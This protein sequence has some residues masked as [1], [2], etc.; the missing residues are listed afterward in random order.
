MPSL[1]TLHHLNI[2]IHVAAG[3][4][5]MLAGLIVLSLPKGDRRHRIGGRITLSLAGLG[6]AAALIGAFVFRGRVDLMGVSV[7]TSYQIW[8]GLRSLRLKDGGRRPLDF[9][10]AL[11]LF[12]LGL[13]VLYLYRR[14]GA[15]Y[16][17]PG[18]VYAT[19]GGM[20]F[21]GGWDLLRTAFPL[22]W[23]LRLNP[24]EHGFKMTSLIGALVSVACGTLLKDNA[25]YASL[26]ASGVFMVLGLVL[27]VRAA[28]RA[29]RNSPGVVP[30]MSLKARLNTDSD[31]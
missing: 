5:A 3:S 17:G 16:W 9:L 20:T 28:M 12:G 4:L 8:S 13:G 1:S 6:I 7:L 10:P 14:G 19:V 30:S 21:Y 25:V 26:T 29:R 2:L 23:R 15:F 22:S 24:A 31:A 27:A 11:I 18:L